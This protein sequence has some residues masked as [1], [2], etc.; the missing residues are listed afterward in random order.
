[1]DPD[2][3][4]IVDTI[5]AGGTVEEAAQRISRPVATLRRWLAQGRKDPAGQWGELARKADGARVAR[6]RVPEV[7][8]DRLAEVEEFV[9]LIDVTPEM[10]PRI[11]LLRTI[12]KKLD[13]AEQTQTGIAAMAAERLAARYA[14]LL[15]E[16]QPMA[17]SDIDK[18]VVALWSGVHEDHFRR[19]LE[20]IADG[21]LK[22][23]KAVSAART[24]LDQAQSMDGRVRK[25][26][27]FGSPNMPGGLP[28]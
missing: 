16:A 2:H 14:E 24:E 13:W 25:H 12:A 10:K 11:G 20:G 21:T 19:V 28:K 5:L 17:S 1:L 15:D 27:L 7:T 4:L 9:K 22:G 26:G 3:Q 18:L 8:G 23:R 6:L